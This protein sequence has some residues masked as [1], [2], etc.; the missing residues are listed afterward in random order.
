MTHGVMGTAGWGGGGEGQGARAMTHDSWLAM[1]G[2]EG[3]WGGQGARAMVHGYDHM[4]GWAV[5]GRPYLMCMVGACVGKAGSGL[6]IPPLLW[7]LDPKTLLVRRRHYDLKTSTHRDLF[8]LFHHVITGDQVRGWHTPPPHSSIMSSQ[9]TR[10]RGWH[11]PPPHSSIVSSHLS[12]LHVIIHL[13][14][15]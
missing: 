1:A 6:V 8:S 2:W 14:P 7:T 13:H 5:G 4:M 10:L 15:S 12:L 3:G 9:G 11:T